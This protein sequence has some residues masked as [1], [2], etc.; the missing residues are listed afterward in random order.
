MS[1][2]CSFHLKAKIEPENI[3]NAD[4]RVICTE[5]PY[6]VQ[7]NPDYTN[8]GWII[9]NLEDINQLYTFISSLEG[10]KQINGLSSAFDERIRLNYEVIL[11][12]SSEIKF[13]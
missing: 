2:T 6:I 9:I 7:G 1:N 5:Q 12:N 8:S 3:N 10:M 4:R 11:Q 13:R